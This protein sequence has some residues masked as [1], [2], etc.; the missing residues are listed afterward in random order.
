MGEDEGPEVEDEGPEDAY[1]WFW[2]WV[3][4]EGEGV[5]GLLDDWVV[6]VVDI[7]LSS[8]SVYSFLVS[9]FPPMR[10]SYTTSAV[11]CES[12]DAPESAILREL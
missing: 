1:E 8:P 9:M 10:V 3:A 4:D 5:D 11:L 12:S 6:I 2:F 7:L